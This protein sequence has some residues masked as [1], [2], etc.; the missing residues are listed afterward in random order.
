MVI[1]SII[2]NDD[3]PVQKKIKRFCCRVGSYALYSNVAVFSWN[4]AVN[5]QQ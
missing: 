4:A 1:G 5:E 3:I 2:E